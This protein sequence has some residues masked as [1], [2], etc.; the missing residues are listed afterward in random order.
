MCVALDALD[1]VVKVQS[2]SGQERSIP[3]IRHYLK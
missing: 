3:F 2:A 1:A